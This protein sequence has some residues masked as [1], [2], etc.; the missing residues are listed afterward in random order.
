LYIGYSTNLKNRLARHKVGKVP[1]TKDRR[2]LMIIH[3]EVFINQKDAKSR[4]KYLKSGYG[5]KQLYQSIKN[6]LLDT[7]CM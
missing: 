7:K 4:E 6:I 3:Y 5:R 2:P 1:S